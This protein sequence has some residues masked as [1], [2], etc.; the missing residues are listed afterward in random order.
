MKLTD[1]DPALRSRA[2]Q[3]LEKA[4]KSTNEA[5]FHK[6]TREVHGRP[7]I[8]DQPPLVYHADPSE[9]DIHNELVPFFES[10]RETLTPDRRVL[11]NRYQFV[12]AAHKV[13]GVGSVGTVCFVALFMADLDDPLFLQVKEARPSVLEGPAGSSDYP[14]NGERV[15]IGQR[16][17]QSASD[18]FLGWARGPGDR[19]YYVRQ[20]RDHKISPDLATTTQRVLV[21]YARLCGRTLARGHAKSGKA[22]QISGYLGSGRNFDQALTDYAVA[23]ADQVEKD[24][25]TFR[26]AVRAGRFPTETSSSEMEAA[27]R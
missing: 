7:R 13:V 12:D 11:F 19:D 9:A 25:E 26:S 3:A 22:A 23:Y 21:G 15:V 4:R 17:M 1:K 24:Y 8:F 5:V 2:D 16:V 27:I 18:I 20:L 6:L 10:Y 14:N